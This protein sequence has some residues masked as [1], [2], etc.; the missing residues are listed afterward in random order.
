MFFFCSGYTK[1][2]W[3]WTGYAK[4]F[5]CLSEQSPGIYV[6][7]Y[8]KK[9]L[10]RSYLSSEYISSRL[11]WM[12]VPVTAQRDRARS[13]HTAMDVWTLGFLMLWAS[14]RITRA[15]AI[16]KRGGKSEAYNQK[17]QILKATKLTGPGPQT[18][19]SIKWI[20]HMFWSLFLPHDQSPERVSPHP[21]SAQESP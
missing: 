9:E 13:L 11:F 16:R 5:C 7:K 8:S 3:I 1:T 10:N 20:I 12:G 6:L 14:S 2:K 21:P 15:Q 17:K 18:S 4:H 19:Q